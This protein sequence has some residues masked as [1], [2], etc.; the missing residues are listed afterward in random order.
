[1]MRRC[2]QICGYANIPP[3]LQRR[4]RQPLSL[5]W[6][7]RIFRRGFQSARTGACALPERLSLRRYAIRERVGVIVRV[8]T[9]T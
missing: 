7:R 8:I 2:V 6:A 9:Q 3:L 4:L 1:M 5:R